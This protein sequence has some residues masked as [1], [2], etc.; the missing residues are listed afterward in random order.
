MNKNCGHKVPCGCKD[1]GLTTPPPCNESGP[2]AG[3]QCAELMCQECISHCQY[4]MEATING[5]TFSVE[6]G[7]RLDQVLQKLFVFLD[8]SACADLVATGLR[9]T[10]VGTDQITV[11]WSGDAAQ[12]WVVNWD[13]GTPLTANVSAGSFKYTITNLAPDTEYSIW[14]DTQGQNCSSVVLKVRTK[15]L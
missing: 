11:S 1:S 12:A 15:E 6:R 7:M 4:P 10:D 2:C 3:E 9:I 14:I 5:G 13:D 8:D